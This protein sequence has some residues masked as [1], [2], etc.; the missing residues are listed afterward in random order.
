MGNE[1]FTRHLWISFGIVAA[2]IIIAGG[3][4]YFFANNLSASADAIVSARTAVNGQDAAV[5]NLADLKQQAVQA[6][7]YQTAIDELIPDQYGLVPFTQWFAQQGGP[8]NVAASAAFQ[9]GVTPS[10]GSTPGNIAF[11]F[12]AS[13]SLG[14]IISFLEFVST[15]SSGFL[16]AFNA[17]NVTSNGTDYTITGGGTVFSQ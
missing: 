7:P 14:N 9:G 15:Q 3:A 2:S 13:G 4:L 11:S 5:A 10:S 12:T 8:Y 6:A 16:V 17:F 1:R